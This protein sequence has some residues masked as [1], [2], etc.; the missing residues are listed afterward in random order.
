MIQPSSLEIAA[1]SSNLLNHNVNLVTILHV[2]VFWGLCFVEAFTI[3]EKADIVGTEL[4]GV[5]DTL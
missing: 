4:Y 5:I 3:E 1:G 2:E